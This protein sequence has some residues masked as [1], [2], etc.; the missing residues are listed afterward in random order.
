MLLVES[1]RLVRLVVNIL[2]NDLLSIKGSKYY[3]YY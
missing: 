3:N 1:I 2:A